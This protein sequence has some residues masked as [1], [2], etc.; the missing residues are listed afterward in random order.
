MPMY[1]TYLSA[2]LMALALIAVWFPGRFYRQPYWLWLLGSVLVVASFTPL[3][4]PLALVWISIAL[5]IF[6][7]MQWQPRFRCW[8][9]IPL[10]IYLFILGL[11]VLPGFARVTL[12]APVLLG[13]G[14][15]PY[16]LR[17]GLAKPIAGLLVL[18]WLAPRCHS[19]HDIVAMIKAWPRWLIPVVLVLVFVTILGVA[20]D[21]KWLWWTPLFFVFN[22]VFTVLPE[23]VFF[24]TFLQQPL[25]NRFGDAWWIIVLMGALF[26]L[27]HVLPTDM[28][29]LRLFV[30]NVLAGMAYAWVF[31]QFKRIEA[32]VLTHILV[33][34]LH[35]IL[36]TY[37]TAFS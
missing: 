6:Y 7:A 19:L 17:L 20:V 14:T 32:A 35:F 33:N 28:A 15:I 12:I 25:H 37:P 27:A 5:A 21:L 18:A 34:T 4:A 1:L 23:E 30:V 3:L 16:G 29:M 31:S 11:G 2:V 22:A 36:L 26:A 9:M 24:R 10:G 13:D 8:L